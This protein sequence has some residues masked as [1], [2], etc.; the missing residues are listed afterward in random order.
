MW[1]YDRA[2]ALCKEVFRYEKTHR[3][4]KRRSQDSFTFSYDE[5]TSRSIAMADEY[6]LPEEKHTWDFVIR[7]YRHYY[8]EGK[9]SFAYWL[10]EDNPDWFPIS[11]I[12]S[13]IR[14]E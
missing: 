6:R 5:L 1:L 13:K 3:T 11:F 8:R 9:W 2:L 4:E 7:S 12:V 10:A 14:G